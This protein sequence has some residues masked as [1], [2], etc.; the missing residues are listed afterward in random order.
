MRAGARLTPPSRQ[1]KS[2]S[3]AY[4]LRLTKS[5]PSTFQPDRYDRSCLQRPPLPIKPSLIAMTRTIWWIVQSSVFFY[6]NSKLPQIWT[7]LPSAVT[8]NF[9]IHGCFSSRKWVLNSS[10]LSGSLHFSFSLFYVYFLRTIDEFYCSLLLFSVLLF[11][12]QREREV[13]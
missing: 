12:K 11:K 1:I 5:E 4:F 3:P 13:S 6:L 7:I 9:W 8:V 10:A 2:I